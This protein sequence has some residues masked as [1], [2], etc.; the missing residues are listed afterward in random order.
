MIPLRDFPKTFELNELAKGYFPHKFNTDENQHYVGQY[1]DKSYYG[2]E[3]MKKADREKFEE[4]YESIGNETFDFRNEMSEYC[5]SDVDILRRGYMKFREL[6]IEIASIDPFQYITIASVCQAIYKSKFLPE[7]TIGI[8]DEAQV[9]TYSVKAIKWLKYISQKEN[10]YI[11][12][13]CNEGE[14]GIVVN[15]NRR[16]L[17]PL[18]VDGYCEI[19]KTVCQF[20]GC[21]WHGCKTCYEELTANRSLSVWMLLRRG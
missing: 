6:F 18:K 20:H 14:Q 13:A 21:C 12:H 10:I 17:A 19:T 16:F 7:N 11:R 1:P 2:Y 4:W 8:C 15:G 3:E 5:K 9:D